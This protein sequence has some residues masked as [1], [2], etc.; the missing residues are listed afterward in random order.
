MPFANASDKWIMTWDEVEVAIEKLVKDIKANLEVEPT[1][2]I[3]VAKGGMIPAAM[4]LQYFPGCTLHVIQVESYYR[5]GKKEPGF[6]SFLNSAQ[7]ELLN[8]P[9]T[10]LV[11]DI[12]DSGD[13]YKL[14]HDSGLDQAQ[15]CFMLVRDTETDDDPRYEYDFLGDTVDPKRWVEFPWEPITDDD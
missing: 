7:L 8:K 12:L 10:L 6:K 2:I 13:T 4:L 9:T 1:A 3:A 14:I 11:D 15:G 5:E